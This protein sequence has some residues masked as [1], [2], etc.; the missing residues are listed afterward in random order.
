MMENNIEKH[1]CFILTF[2]I[3]I[4]IIGIIPYESC[5]DKL[6][7]IEILNCGL[8]WTTVRYCGFRKIK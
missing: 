8:I 2:Q 1:M 4:F 3:V 5:A 6:H 7:F